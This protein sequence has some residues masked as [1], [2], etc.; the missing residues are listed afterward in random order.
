M[1]TGEHQD[2]VYLT[3][4]PLTP[5]QLVTHVTCPEA[6]G[7][8]VFIGTTREMTEGRQTR[9]LEY[10]AYEE[11]ARDQ[12]AHIVKTAREQWPIVRCAVAHR[13]GRVDLCEASVVIAISCPHRRDAFAAASWMI[14]SIKQVVPIWKCEHWADGSHEWIHPTIPDP[15]PTP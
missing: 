10:E 14:D 6:G 5:A 1:A 15:S 3:S 12:L 7:V 13:L 9:Y 4:Q 8:V 11:M 2:W